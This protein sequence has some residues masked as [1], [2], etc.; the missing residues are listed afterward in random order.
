M[1]LPILIVTPVYAAPLGLVSRPKAAAVKRATRN[2][3]SILDHNVDARAIPQDPDSAEGISLNHEEIGLAA[4][5]DGAAAGKAQRL[6]RSA[7]RRVDG[8][9]WAQAGL[10]HVHE[11]HRIVPRRAAVVAHRDGEPHP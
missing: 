11:L 8:A 6:R 2:R 7:R 1:A 10:D 9:Q 3:N 5:L 4:R